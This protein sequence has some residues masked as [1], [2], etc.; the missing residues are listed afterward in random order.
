MLQQDTLSTQPQ[1]TK[2]RRHGYRGYGS[3]LWEDHAGSHWGRWF[4]GVLLPEAGILSESTRAE[5]RRTDSKT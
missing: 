2:R 3:P 5:T 1:K 4:G